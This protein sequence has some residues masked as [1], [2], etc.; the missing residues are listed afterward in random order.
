M[1][2]FLDAVKNRRSIYGITNKSPIPDEKI[3]EIINTAVKHT[4]SAFNGQ[5]QRVVV[6]F[7]DSHKKL[8]QIVENTLRKIVPEENFSSTKQKIGSFSAGYGTI[9][10][11]DE[12]NTTKSLQEQF[13]LYKDNFEVWAEHQNAMLQF[14]IWTA[15][16]DAGFGASLQHYN[17]LIDEEVKNTFQIP[18]SWRLIAQMPFGLPTSPAGEKEFLPLSERIIVKK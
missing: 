11:F 4:P 7:G 18:P 8:W 14:V 1:K 6:L 17:P 10:Y 2:N 9:L 15:L 3:I 13:P 16:E 5:S 12:T